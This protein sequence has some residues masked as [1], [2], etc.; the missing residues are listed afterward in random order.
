MMIELGEE[1]RA[2][3]AYKDVAIRQYLHVALGIREQP[4]GVGVLVHQAGNHF[5]FVDLDH[6][7]AGLIYSVYVA[8]VEDCN[9]TVGMA[10]GVML[11]GGPDTRTHFE[12]AILPAKTPDDLSRLPVDLVHRASPAGRDEQVI[13]VIYIYGVDVEVIVGCVVRLLQPDVL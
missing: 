9:S 4:V 6:N 7:G 11:K 3:P 8:I 10:A 12:V 13:L 2:S 1:R 5:I